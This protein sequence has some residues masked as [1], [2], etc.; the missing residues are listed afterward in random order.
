STR[1]QEK[2]KVRQPLSKV[3]VDGNYKD[4]IGDLTG[5][6]MEELN[7]HEV[8]FE[9]DLDKYM[10][11][12][13]KP[14]F[15][16]AGP[17]LGKN[18]KEFGSKLSG[19]DAKETISKIA[20]GPLEMELGGEKYE[21]TED[22]LDVRISSKEGF[23]VGMD[24][25]VFVI[26]DTTLTRELIDQGYVREIISKIQQ[27]RKQADFEM[28]DQIKIYLEADDEISKAANDAKDFIMDETIAVSIE[29]ASGLDS[30]DINGH[31]TGIK[32][33]RI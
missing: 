5:L 9:D 3:I 4:I 33:E 21:I 28:M 24:N 7:V 17:V 20:Q 25:N 22:Y 6:I 14:N 15:K 30:F 10:N 23:V 18:I 16:T 26:L 13:I 8:Q 12:Q 2:L 1:E 29:N 27:L 19:L 32:V 31:K 11:F